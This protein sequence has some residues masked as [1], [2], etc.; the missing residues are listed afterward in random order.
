MREQEPTPGFLAPVR[1]LL[2]AGLEAVQVRLALLGN[3]LEEQ[4][5]R[6]AEGL[7]L[8]VLGAM[9]VAIAVLL[10]CGF[11]L[12]LFWEGHR[13]LALGTMTVLV[14]G[15]GLALLH[16]GRARLRSSGS[17]FQASLDELAQDRETL[18]PASTESRPPAA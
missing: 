16:A 15:G 7:A 10:A 5:L 1:Q 13:L 3:E 6:I 17:M 8:A 11:V 4:K 12:L 14:A 2:D 18:A 9:L